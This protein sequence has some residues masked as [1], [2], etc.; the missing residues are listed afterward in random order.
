LFV[1]D[2]KYLHFLSCL[3]AAQ[4]FKHPVGFSLSVSRDLDHRFLIPLAL[5][6]I[7]TSY[8][9]DAMLRYC[10][11]F[12]PLYAF[13]IASRVMGI[14][15]MW[16]NWINLHVRNS[17]KVEMWISRFLQWKSKTVLPANYLEHHIVCIQKR[18]FSIYFISKDDT[19]LQVL[20]QIVVDRLARLGSSISRSI[21]S[22]VRSDFICL[23]CHA[24][25]LPV[26]FI[27]LRFIFMPLTCEQDHFALELCQCGDHYPLWIMQH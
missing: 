22:D 3:R 9:R 15:N 17:V 8:T 6:F 12:L 5:A 4:F 7:T 25:S 27:S 10:Q 11:Q 20:S 14:S 21:N 24:L 2:N 16:L 23:T 26:I 1:F 18:I 13:L 19:S